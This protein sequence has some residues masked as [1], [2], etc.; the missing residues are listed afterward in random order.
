MSH[1]NTKI[2]KFDYKFDPKM[3]K[4]TVQQTAPL[5]LTSLSRRLVWRQRLFKDYLELVR[6]CSCHDWCVKESDEEI[7]RDEASSMMSE[8]VLVMPRR[9]RSDGRT[10]ILRRPRE[11]SFRPETFSRVTTPRFLLRSVCRVACRSKE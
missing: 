3:T 8:M 5:F 4:S 7:D 6:C 2:F 1:R 9:V 11:I 10:E